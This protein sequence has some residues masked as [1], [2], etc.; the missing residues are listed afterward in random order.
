VTRLRSLGSLATRGLRQRPGRALLTTAG[1]SLGVALIFGVLLLTATIDSTFRGLFESVYG[2]TDLVASSPDPGARLPRGALDRARGV[3]GV[4]SVQGALVAV[5]APVRR[6]RVDEDAEL[7]LAGVDPAAPDSSGREIV[8]GRAVRRGMEIE[9]EERWAGDQE[10]EVGERIRLATPAGVRS[11]RVVGTFRFAR[12]FGF[13]AEG[14]GTVP[15]GTARRILDRPR[16]FDE[17]RIDA[18]D[19]LA[20]D[21]VRRR[22]ER[23]LG[24]GV[25][26]ETPRG[27]SDEVAEQLRALDVL[28]VFFAAM[29]LFVGGFL[30]F[31]AFQVTVMQRQRE[32]GMLRTLGATRGAIARLI[33][34]EA[35]ILGVVGT[36]VGLAIGVALAIG[37]VAL[38]EAI[39]FPVSGLAF[40]T[41]ALVAAL[42][43][44][45]VVAL[46]GALVPAVRAGRTSPLRALLGVAESRR[47]PSRRRALAG[48]AVAALGLAGVFRLASADDISGGVAATGMAG[49]LALFAGVAL[50]APFLIVPLVRAMSWPLRRVA[51]IEGRLAADAAA[52]N[53]SR[54]AATASGL[55]IGLALVTAFGSLGSSFLG[56]VQDELDTAFAR[57]LTIQPRGFQPGAGQQQTISPRL[58]ERVRATPGVEVAAP[59]RL[60]PAEDVLPGAGEGL[61]LGFDPRLHGRIDDSSYASGLGEDEVLAAVARGGVTVGEAIAKE[62]R[63]A[64]GDRVR[65]RGA[66]GSRVARV[67]AVVETSIFGGQTIGVSLATIEAVFGVEGDSSIA[68]KAESA[69]ARDGV[70]RRLE[71]IVEREYP[72]LQ[73]LSNDE[74][75]EEIESQVDEQFGFF[76][77]LLF[78]AVLVS[79][80]GIVNTLSM[81]VLERTREIGLLRALGSSRWQVRRAI[82]D[83]SLLLALVGTLLGLVVGVALGWVFVE[84]IASAVPSVT[85]TPPYGTIAAV[86]AAG[87]V[88]GL[89]AAIVP[90]RRAARMDV[91]EALAY[92]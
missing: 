61:V 58:L 37:L 87:V 14:F 82:A 23:A 19:G 75:K 15:L 21:V 51:P 1:I 8:A 69:E 90:A 62:E 84:G 55:M 43:G 48:V 10:V 79:L 36:A 30:I 56:S 9:L 41:T 72:Q 46:A 53:P 92:E 60:F 31:N 77:V 88:L 54:T 45:I 22:L 68:V 25:G 13:G 35:L 32:L 49:V 73:V 20:L 66:A 89:L 6:G 86:A 33:L 34:R 81:N 29:G 76:N 16:G 7:N 83:E 38:M 40:S 74:L 80:F 44:G 78:L 3:R 91:I 28:L 59:E 67:A 64:P 52:A 42:A 65:L 27:K 12:T 2:R 5:V 39:G 63:L 71:R 50:V 26:V 4:E 24:A 11:L 18:A 57:D 47:P 85:Y 17:L 70:E